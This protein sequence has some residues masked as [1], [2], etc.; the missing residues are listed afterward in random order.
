MAESTQAARRK[1]TMAKAQENLY[2]LNVAN[3]VCDVD[4]QKVGT[5]YNPYTSTPVVT[6]AAFSA[7]TYTVGTFS[8]DADSLQINRRAVASEI[9]G[10]YHLMSSEISL[11]QDRGANMGKGIS[12]VIDGYVL[13]LPKTT[14]GVTTLDDA[15][16]GGSAGTAITVGSGSS[17]GIDDIINVATQEVELGNAYG[18][19]FMVVS[20]YESRDLKGYLQ[21]TGNMV[22]D[23]VLR[24]GFAVGKNV[25]KV[26]TTF[27]GVD[28]FQSNNITQTVVLGLATNPTNGDTITIAGVEITFVAT[29]SGGASEIHITGSV[30]ATAANLAE[31]LNAAGANDEAEDTNT[32]YS[33]ASQ[34]DQATLSRLGISAVATGASDIVTITT[35]GVVRVSETLTDGTDTWATPE[36]YLV[37]GEYGFIN[38]YQPTQG[39]D[40]EEKP[41]SGTDG[42]EVFLRQFYNATIWTRNLTRGVAIRVN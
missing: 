25:N 2:A 16:F 11:M 35:K 42:K 28:V 37:F 29:L 14:S 23:E 19:K 7:N 31:W 32:G 13:S 3:M 6:D 4:T 38:L 5:V 24:N 17:D 22:M 41:V 10:E 26:G 30:D 12:Q 21:T 36:R 8:Q 20:S 9:V 40:Y 34:E 1:F 39:M 18:K 33:A 15:Y 27:S